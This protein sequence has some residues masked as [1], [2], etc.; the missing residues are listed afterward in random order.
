MS[1]R[2]NNPNRSQKQKN[3]CRFLFLGCALYGGI[4]L[5]GG[6]LV[7]ILYW[8]LRITPS[9]SESSSVGIIGGADGPTAILVAG[10]ALSGY[11][12]PVLLVIVGIAGFLW[13]SKRK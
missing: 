8:I 12:I 5:L 10:P 6:V 11:F 13:L 9:V 7:N 3:P 4:K 2:D 1:E